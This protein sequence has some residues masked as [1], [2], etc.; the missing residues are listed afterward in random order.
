M[1]KEVETHNSTEIL[2]SGLSL[3]S[4]QYPDIVTGVLTD[5]GITLTV[6]VNRE[7][8]AG[9]SRTV[10][11]SFML[12][13]KEQQLVAEYELGSFGP[14]ELFNETEEYVLYKR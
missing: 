14:D 9:C 2:E 7:L 1:V 8:K 6:M 5:D 4:I 3:D 13:K 10:S 12:P 11:L